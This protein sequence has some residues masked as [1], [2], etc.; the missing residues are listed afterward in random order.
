MGVEP[1]YKSLVSCLQIGQ[2]ELHLLQ[3]KSS[4]FGPEGNASMAMLYKMMSDIRESDS[5]TE[6]EL[7]A[8]SKLFRVPPRHSAAGQACS[9][10]PHANVS[11]LWLVVIGH[12]SPLK[13]LSSQTRHLAR[14]IR[15]PS[16]PHKRASS[17]G[18]RSAKSRTPGTFRPLQ[19][20]WTARNN[21]VTPHAIRDLQQRRA[22]PGRDRRKSG[23]VQRETPRD[24]LRNL[25]RS[26]FPAHCTL[27][28]ADS[29]AP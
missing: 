20:S 13:S 27:N 8:S 2:L 6:D 16:T 29:E 24:A 14:L 3:R 5:G 1:F 4:G 22:T 19:A 25:S 28:W 11:N 12:R 17:V 7:S 26:W 23:R 10:T 18:T 9:V 21:P 15:D